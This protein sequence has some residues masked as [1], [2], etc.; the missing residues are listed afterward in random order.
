V[1]VTNALAYYGREKVFRACSKL[2][3]KDKSVDDGRPSCLPIDLV[4][5]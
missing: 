2:S 5:V 4:S 3:S 1:A